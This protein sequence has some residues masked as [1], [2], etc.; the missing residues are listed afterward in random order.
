MD[1]IGD[2]FFTQLSS[3]IVVW[4]ALLIFDKTRATIFNSINLSRCNNRILPLRLSN[5]SC[6]CIVMPPSENSSPWLARTL[7]RYLPVLIRQSGVS[8]WGFLDLLRWSSAR[9][10]AP[11]PSSPK[12][13]FHGPFSNRGECRYQ[14]GRSIV[15]QLVV[16]IIMRLFAKRMSV[17]F[18]NSG[19]PN[20][21]E[22]EHAV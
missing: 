3:T 14:A 17:R 1:I 2:T 9:L 8:T 11:L 15:G 22:K 12:E 21:K 7:F 5:N 18:A 19:Q 10:S 6:R 20:S 4:V 16:I 13:R